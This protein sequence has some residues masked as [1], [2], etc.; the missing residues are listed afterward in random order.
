M[1]ALTCKDLRRIEAICSWSCRGHAFRAV[2][3][4]LVQDSRT[5]PGLSVEAAQTSVT[6]PTISP[7]PAPPA[8][9]PAP[10][11]TPTTHHPPPHHHDHHHHPLPQPS[12]YRYCCCYCYCLTTATATAM[13]TA[14]ATTTTTI[15]STA[16]VST[17]TATI[18]LLPPLRLLAIL[19]TIRSEVKHNNAHIV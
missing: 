19:I 10:A 4:M 6:H 17:T 18:Q 2:A 1:T 5:S 9:A 12:P 3:S 16:I 11:P 14:T 15:T 8:P 7:A 13:T